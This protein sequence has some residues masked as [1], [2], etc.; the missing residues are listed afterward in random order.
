MIGQ[1]YLEADMRLDGIIE[2]LC[3]FFSRAAAGVRRPEGSGQR[4]AAGN[5]PAPDEDY[6]TMS[7]IADFIRRKRSVVPWPN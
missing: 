5:A 1:Y 7:Q 3:D 2:E 6:F 4:A